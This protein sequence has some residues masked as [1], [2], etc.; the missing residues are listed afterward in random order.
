MKEYKWAILGTGSIANEMANAFKI[1][2]RKIYSVGNRTYTKAVDFAKKY[3]I[4]KVYKDYNEM[5]DDP[6]VD[7]IYIATL[8]NTHY[9]FAKK[10]IKNKKNVLI[11]KAITLNSKELNTLI[12]LAKKNKV[13]IAEAMTIYHM[14]LYKK[15]NKIIEDG[16]LG[17]VNLITM[18]F[19]SFKEYDMNNRFFNKDFAGG[20]LLDIGVY[21]ISFVRYFFTSCPN[22]LLTTV[23]F[24]PTG[25]DEQSSIIMENKEGQ[26][27]TIMLSLHSKQPKRAMISCQK[28]Y[29]EIMEYPRAYKAKITYTDTNKSQ[30]IT[31]G[32]TFKALAYEIKDMEKSIKNKNNNMKML[33]TKDVMDIMTKLRKKWGLIYKEEI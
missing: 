24:A 31:S 7:I 19:G 1:Q 20:A 30:I 10:A 8:H 21:A 32:K 18:N 29:I 27:A 4:E 33:Y 11:E 5:F 3:N 22:K 14:P 2:N 17:N 16:L 26:M 25:V 9:E 15:L 12:A 28:G 13:I 23:K 6:N